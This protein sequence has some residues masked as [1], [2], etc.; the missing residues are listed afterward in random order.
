MLLPEELISPRQTYDLVL[1]KGNDDINHNI[2]FFDIYLICTSSAWV[3]NIRLTHD[4]YLQTEAITQKVRRHFFSY[5]GCPGEKVVSTE[6]LSAI[7]VSTTTQ[8]FQNPTDS[9]T[10]R[11][12]K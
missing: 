7:L 10:K 6:A 2:M 5:Q 8:N 1:S 4:P 11:V 9:G 3:K 12:V